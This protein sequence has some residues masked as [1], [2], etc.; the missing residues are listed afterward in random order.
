LIFGQPGSDRL[1]TAEQ[2]ARRALAAAS[3]DDQPDVACEALD[4]LGSCVRLQD[5]AA[6]D[7]LYER[8]LRLAE[9][10]ELTVH[11]IRMLFQ[12]GADEGIR[13]GDPSRLLRAREVALEAG[14]VVTALDIDCELA[15]VRINRGEYAA[16]AAL[17]AG[18]ENS[19]LRLRLE[20]SRMIALGIRV[21]AAAHAGQR[22]EA[23]ELHGEYQRLGG[24][25][26]DF[27]AAVAGY[28]LATGSLLNEERDRAFQ[29]LG[30]AVRLEESLQ[31][32]YL[33]FT[34][35]PH[36]LLAAL[37]GDAGWPEYERI[38]ETA[39]GQ[40]SWNRQF[41]LLAQ[42]VLAGRSERSCEASGAVEQ[43]LAVSTPFPLA[44][45]LGLRLIGQ[46]AL[47]DGWGDPVPWLRTAEE[48]FHDTAGA[49]VASACRT[50]L[51][52][53]GT[54][55]PRR[56]QGGTAVPS[57]LRG[58]GVTS[59][60]YEV[61][62]LLAERLGNREIGE[63]LFLSPR[64]VEKH[65]ASLLAKAGATDRIDLV[66]RFSHLTPDAGR[67]DLPLATP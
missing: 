30:W 9:R 38:A 27:A 23:R 52:G 33:S 10:H 16:A 34:H 42:A 4:V 19:A 20:E 48:F 46:A 35:G 64:T 41:L 63:R 50:L 28:G 37:A 47:A 3:D 8:A 45:H 58:A 7:E 59:R 40:A 36:L 55:V 51:R 62:V 6:A 11:R 24:L 12:L 13:N 32:H 43:F 57:E 14:A 65:V 15:V 5:I 29:Q 22:A 49:P 60:E 31:T 61:L 25:E 67:P 17:S 1:A 56:R 18:A 66:R 2:L 26:L 53:T 21:C 44:R 39:S 54:K